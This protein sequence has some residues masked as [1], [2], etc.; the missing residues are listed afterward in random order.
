M[1]KGQ[2]L[3]EATNLGCPRVETPTAI[4]TAVYSGPTEISVKA[5]IPG[6]SPAAAIPAAIPGGPAAAIPTAIQGGPAAALE[7]TTGSAATIETSTRK[8]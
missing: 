8:T 5:A 3:G 4:A 1:A 6:D 7:A 2:T